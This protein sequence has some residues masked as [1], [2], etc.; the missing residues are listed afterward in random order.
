[1]HV[2]QQLYS[3][4]SNNNK[5][6]QIQHATLDNHG[7]S[8]LHIIFEFPQPKKPSIKMIHNIHTWLTT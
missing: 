3:N 1:M 5:K 2:I 8:I 4:F 6:R 7:P